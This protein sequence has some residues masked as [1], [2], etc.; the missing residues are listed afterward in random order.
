MVLGLSAAKQFI[1]NNL[2]SPIARVILCYDRF[3]N[4]ISA[5]PH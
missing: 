5:I 1:K 3:F 4:A 2:H